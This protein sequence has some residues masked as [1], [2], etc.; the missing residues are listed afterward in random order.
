MHT[1]IPDFWVYILYCD[2]QSFYTGY[3]INLNTRYRAH[4]LGK[5]SK[6][7][8][9]FVPLE[10]VGAWPIYGTK[11]QAMQI[12][13]IIKNQTKEMKQTL[14]DNPSHL[15]QLILVGYSDF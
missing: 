5:A 2:N 11:A 10:M 7:T 9:S 15:E 4:S 14:I 13:R 1:K 8:R 3:T 12:E 6:Y